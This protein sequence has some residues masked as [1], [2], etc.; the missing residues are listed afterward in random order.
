MLNRLAAR[1]LNTAAGRD[2]AIALVQQHGARALC[3]LDEQS[4]RVTPDSERRRIFVV[5][6]R[7]IEKLIPLL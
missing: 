1:L 5:A 7:D 3:V 4:Q 6:R 2:L